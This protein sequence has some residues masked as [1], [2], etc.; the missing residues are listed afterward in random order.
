LGLRVEKHRA[1][2]ED[3]WERGV[4]VW[5]RWEVVVNEGGRR[6]GVRVGEDW[7]GGLGGRG[8]CV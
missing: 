3:G 8:R 1:G 4:C 2:G 7:G 6:Q 5:D